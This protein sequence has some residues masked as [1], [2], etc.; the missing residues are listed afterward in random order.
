MDLL[1]LYKKKLNFPPPEAT[2]PPPGGRTV[3]SRGA[4][5]KGVYER[6][7]ATKILVFSFIAQPPP[8]RFDSHKL[9]PVFPGQIQPRAARGRPDM[10]VHGQHGCRHFFF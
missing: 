2:A 10:I 1:F 6:A 9:D 8:A 7:A 4:G 3:G 5:T